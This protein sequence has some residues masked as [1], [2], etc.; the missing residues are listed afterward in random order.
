[1]TGLC[2]L[3]LA[4]ERLLDQIEGIGEFAELAA[5]STAWPSS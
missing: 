4:A 5:T 3:D 1:L 2:E